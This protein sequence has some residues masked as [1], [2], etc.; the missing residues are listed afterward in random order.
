M[1]PQGL[2]SYATQGHLI[3]NFH[4]NTEGDP[5]I[6][7]YYR[8]PGRARC[9]EDKGPIWRTTFTDTL[10]GQPRARQGSVV[11]SVLGE[12]H[13]VPLRDNGDLGFP[14]LCP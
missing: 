11:G 5:C 14:C 1:G 13:T 12:T 7:G 3:V 2:S 4:S 10:C 8:N 9:T 6:W